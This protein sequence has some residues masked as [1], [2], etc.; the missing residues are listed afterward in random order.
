MS[1]RGGVL[2]VAT[3]LV[4]AC[5]GDPSLEPPKIHFGEDLCAHCGMIVSEERFATATIVE[6]SERTREI[7]IYDDI[8][9]ML[10]AG[11]PRDGR[12]AA[13]F[14]HDHES[15]SWIAAETAFYV[16][17]AELRTPMLSGLAAWADRKQAESGAKRYSGSVIGFDELP[18]ELP[19]PRREVN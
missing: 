9:C 19:D 16:R 12:I 8:G 5:G 3:A 7:R 2:A 17:G 4:V 10:A 6:R 18:H 13:R 11:S 14:V 1:F 15:L